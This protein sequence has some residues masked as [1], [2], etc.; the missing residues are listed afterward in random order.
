[1]EILKLSVN[2]EEL[3]VMRGARSLLSKR[4]VC[5][6]MMHVAKVQLGWED[7]KGGA[8]QRAEFSSELWGLL[9]DGAMD[10]ALHLDEDVTGQTAG[11]TRQRPE[12]R[13]LRS[14]DELNAVFQGPIYHHDYLV[15]RQRMD[16]VAGAESPCQE[17]FA[18]DH[19]NA[20]FKL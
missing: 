17:S 6:V 18:L 5:V 4:K 16:S 11:D 19:F 10:L 7:L 2:G 15:A 8:A 20:M 1:M 12:T 13:V 9:K 3:N 14:P